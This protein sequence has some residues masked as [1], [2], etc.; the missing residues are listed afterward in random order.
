MAGHGALEY[1]QLLTGLKPTCD[2][3]N[4]WLNGNDGTVGVLRRLIPTKLERQSSFRIEDAETVPGVFGEASDD[5]H[6][7]RGATAARPAD[8]VGPVLRPEGAVDASVRLAHDRFLPRG[9]M[10]PVFLPRILSTLEYCF[11]PFLILVAAR[12]MARPLAGFIER[13]RTQ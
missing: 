1:C 4:A 8:L 13:L 11:A 5:L 10:R 7:V 12:P 2:A 9:T 3:V 6:A